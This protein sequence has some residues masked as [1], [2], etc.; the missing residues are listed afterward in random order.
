MKTDVLTGGE[1]RGTADNN[2]VKA[3]VSDKMNRMGWRS[4]KQITEGITLGP[5]SN[6]RL[7]R[8]SYPYSASK[9]QCSREPHR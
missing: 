9:Q 7:L 8:P 3:F 4:M 5:R 1:L 2:L 6:F